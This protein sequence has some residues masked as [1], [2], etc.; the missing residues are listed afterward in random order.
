MSV[1][2]AKK[3]WQKHDLAAIIMNVFRSKKKDKGL[4]EGGDEAG[5]KSQDTDTA[6]L[7]PMKTFRR[8]KKIKEPELPK[9]ELDL[10][11]ALPQSDDFRTSLLMTG[12]SARFSMLREQDDPSSKMGKAA[13]DSVLFPRRASRMN[14]FD[15]TPKGLSGITEDDS[16]SDP[17]RRQFASI[18]TER[19]HSSYSNDGDGSIMSRG[20]PAEGNNLFG[21]RQ[22]VYKVPVNSSAT[23]G[24]S[25]DTA[26]PAGLGGRAT[27]DDDLTL[28]AFQRIKLREREERERQEQ[29]DVRKSEESQDATTN[30]PGSPSLGG[31]NRNRETSSTTS[32]GPSG[33]RSSTAATSV[34]SQRTGSINNGH[35]QPAAPAVPH[36]PVINGVDRSLTK[37]KRLYENGLDQ[38][39]N[40]QQSSAASRIDNLSRQ[41]REMGVRSPSPTP[42]SPTVSRF[43]SS[44][45][46]FP[47]ARAAPTP[48]VVQPA[49][50]G[51]DFGVTAFTPEAGQA[52]ILAAPLSPPVSE[53]G[54]DDDTALLPIQSNPEQ[55]PDSAAPQ[56]TP[57]HAYDE[58]KYAQRQIQMQKGRDTSPI[59]NDS[60]TRTFP[61]KIAN[62]EFPLRSRAESIVHN[63]EYARSRSTSTAN[64][65]FSPRQRMF[66]PTRGDVVSPSG[67]PPMPGSFSRQRSD[68]SQSSASM[69]PIRAPAAPV[70]IAAPQP[71]K[72]SS[73]W[74]HAS[75]FDGFQGDIPPSSKAS[76][77]SSPEH[78]ALRTERLSGWDDDKEDLQVNITSKQSSRLPSPI[79]T[80][81]RQVISPA[82]DS[83]TLPVPGGLSGLVRQ[84]LRSDSDASSIA[85]SSPARTSDQFSTREAGRNGSPKEL[86]NRAKQLLEQTRFLSSQ[87]DSSAVS[88][89]SDTPS[90]EKELSRHHSRGL[91]TDTQQERDDFANELA[92]RRRKVQENLRNFAESESRSQSPVR[93]PDAANEA[94][95]AKNNRLHF[96]KSKPSRTSLI[97]NDEAPA[98]S[99][100][101][102]I[103]GMG[104]SANNSSTALSN[105]VTNT[106]RYDDNQWKH[107]EEE[108]MRGVLKATKTPPIDDFRQQRRGAQRERERQ[109]MMRHEQL[110][111]I[112]KSAPDQRYRQQMEQAMPHRQA[113]CGRQRHPPPRTREPSREPR[114]APPVSYRG[115]PEPRAGSGAG[116]RNGSAPNSR[117]GTGDRSDSGHS[118][119]YRDERERGRANSQVDEYG[120]RINH[121][122]PHHMQSGPGYGHPSS[123]SRAESRAQPF[124]GYHDGASPIMDNGNYRQAPVAPYVAKTTPP[125]A[126]QPPTG[127]S[128]GPPRMQQGYPDER[129]QR[130]ARKKSIIKSEISDPQFVST[131]SEISSIG[132]QPSGRP[133]EYAPPLPPLDPRRRQPSNPKGMFSGWSRK[134]EYANSSSPNLPIQYQNDGYSA[135]EHEQQQPRQQRKLRKMTSESAALNSRGRQVYAAPGPMPAYPAGNGAPSGMF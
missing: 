110:N 58:G 60:P 53:E 47:S 87:Q 19:V 77:V 70:A 132:L 64:K 78:P 20:K 128:A 94:S 79:E 54:E 7:K 44:Q 124:P 62:A 98:Q 93:R 37:T 6:P 56:P 48:P 17:F 50:G 92:A 59:R 101:T 127:Y 33:A 3:F 2:S 119:S 4:K 34:I 126:Q 49:N 42:A 129:E 113:E 130:R 117:P 106:T 57:S 1:D 25:D 114:D 115:I 12:L 108:M 10:V 55:K 109:I 66:S 135:S 40:R 61:S 72:P 73:A 30:R 41:G 121:P 18:D 76:K 125:L 123:R 133:Q 134:D 89:A 68:T 83:P 39:L 112:G 38:Q 5:R 22:K 13:D 82:Q 118:S 81:S 111:G 84:H 28:S 35:A 100:M 71:T 80:V 51:F 26:A 65:Q 23:R 11:N 69:A 122:S 88:T 116:S 45:R 32:S 86:E 75:A 120:Q 67:P 14:N 43:E 96:L 97:N 102:K 46:Q 36:Q 90:W 8:N 103:L 24:A 85:E 105:S 21:G 104:G 63:Q 29:E 15:F 16:C 131:T 31:Y 95:F 74:E 52:S 27:Y 107:D 99:K 9:F 91:S